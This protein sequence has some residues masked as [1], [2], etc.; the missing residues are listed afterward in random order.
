[1]VKV[2]DVP[3]VRLC[4]DLHS[5]YSFTKVFEDIQNRVFIVIFSCSDTSLLTFCVFNRL[6]L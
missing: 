3:V 2:C 1:M 4:K 6:N 5:D